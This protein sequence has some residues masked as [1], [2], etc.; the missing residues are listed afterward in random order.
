MKC[1]L[2]KVTLGITS[3][4]F[5][6]NNHSISGKLKFTASYQGWR[7]VPYAA[8]TSPGLS[9]THFRTL[10]SDTDGIPTATAPPR[11]SSGLRPRCLLQTCMFCVG[12]GGVVGM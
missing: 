10:A 1:G 2:P 8:F 7:S 9:S 4:P 3:A 11:L 6:S 12:A 5:S